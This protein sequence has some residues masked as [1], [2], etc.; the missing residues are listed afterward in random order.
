MHRSKEMVKNT[1]R[2]HLVAAHVL[3]LLQDGQARVH[4]PVNAVLCACLLG[5]VEGAGSDLAGDA[6]LPADFVQVVHG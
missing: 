2:S 3:Q 5:L 6:L 4:P 1:S